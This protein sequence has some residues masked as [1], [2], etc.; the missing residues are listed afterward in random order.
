MIANFSGCM[1]SAKCHLNTWLHL[2]FGIGI[3]AVLYTVGTQ[4]ESCVPDP[5]LWVNADAR[6][7]LFLLPLLPW[8]AYY[9]LALQPSYLVRRLRD[10]G[11]SG[12]WVLLWYLSL[13]IFPIWPFMWLYWAHIMDLP[14]SPKH[15]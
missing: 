1:S 14:S 2:L 11:R 4:A 10:A 15:D 5:L 13:V 7:T 9:L 3:A 6:G 8:F 12:A